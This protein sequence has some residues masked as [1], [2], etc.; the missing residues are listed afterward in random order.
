MEAEVFLTGIWK[1]Y[2]Q[3]EESLSMPELL[4]TLEAKREAKWKDYKFQAAMQGVSLP[5]DPTSNEGR[6]FDEIKRDA[7][8][9]A[10]GGDP[11]LN[12][13]TNLNGAVASNE[14][15]GINMEE[16]VVYNTY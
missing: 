1:N 15:F 8:I 14:G 13:I 3:L 12:D 11:S 2:E 9:R 5:D 10:Q 4:A 6:T 7:L 16:G